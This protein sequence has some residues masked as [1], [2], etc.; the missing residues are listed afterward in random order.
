[1]SGNGNECKPLVV[2]TVVSSKMM[3]SVVVMVYRL[4][5]HPK[6]GKYIKGRKKYTV[7]SC[8]PAP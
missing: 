6:Y 2:G 4:F 5:K 1:L 3:K 8:A 7:R